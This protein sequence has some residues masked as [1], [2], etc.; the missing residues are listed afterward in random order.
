MKIEI[1]QGEDGG[2]RVLEFDPKTETYENHY[3]ETIRN[4]TKYLL[5]TYA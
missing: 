3:F 1:I 2:W 4:V 5:G